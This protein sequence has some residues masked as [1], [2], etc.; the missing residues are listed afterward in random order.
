MVSGLNEILNSEGPF[1][2][3]APSDVAFG[4]LETG[5]IGDWLKPEN[6]TKLADLLKIHVV[7]GKIEHKDL[8]DGDRL[9]SLNGKELMVEVKEGKVYINGAVI[10]KHDVET[11]NGT[12]HSLDRVL[13]H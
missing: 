3:F 6:K 10:L 2:L 7:E 9:K 13:K 8:L 4:K 11:T 5:T 12:I 1:T